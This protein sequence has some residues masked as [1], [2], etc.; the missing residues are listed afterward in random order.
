MKNPLFGMAVPGLEP[1]QALLD[2]NPLLYLDLTEAVRRGIGCVLCAVSSGALVGFPDRD[3]PARYSGYTM[4]CADMDTARTLCDLLPADG[5]FLLTTHEAFYLPLLQE[6]FGVVSFLGGG[7]YQAAYLDDQPIP[8]PETP[9]TVRQ[10]DLR[11]LPAV[12]ANYKMEG[13][14]YL[15]SRIECGELFGGFM[16]EE[17]VGFAGRHVEGSVGLLEVLPPYRRQGFA[18]VLEGY[19]I[20]RELAQGHIPYGQVL[21]ENTPSLALQRSLGMTISD[22]KLYWVSRN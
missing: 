5:D 13:E 17:L 1:C 6:R 21:V 12:V 18:T 8:L 2:T 4:L 22:E 7:N 15:R 3:N 19:L 20:N 14:A 9:L 16:G 11:H 10:L